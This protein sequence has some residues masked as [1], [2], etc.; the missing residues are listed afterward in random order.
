[1]LADSEAAEDLCREVEQDLMASLAGLIRRAE[2][3]G[4]GRH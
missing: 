2:N 3:L 1:M 4:R